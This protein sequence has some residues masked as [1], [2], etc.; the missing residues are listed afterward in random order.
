MLKSRLMTCP[1]AAVALSCALTSGAAVTAD[2]KPILINS[3]DPKTVVSTI[4]KAQEK[5]MMFVALD[6]PVDALDS[7]DAFLANNNC[8]AGVLSGQ[9]AKAAVLADFAG[10]PAKVATLNLLA[11]PAFA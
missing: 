10:K 4:K 2:V 7:I 8:M 11:A 9:Y 3:S 1:A 5:G 6:S